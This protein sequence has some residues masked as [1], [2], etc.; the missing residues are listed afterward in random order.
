MGTS[1]CAAAAFLDFSKAFDAVHHCL[2]LNKLEKYGARGIAHRLMASYLG[3]IKHYCCFDDHCSE[4]LS[5]TICVPQG[6]GGSL[7]SLLYILYTNDINYLM[8]DFNPILFADDTTL[9][10]VVENPTVLSLELNLHLYKISDW[11]N[12][13]R[14]ALNSQKSI[15]VYFQIVM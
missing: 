11:C 10:L 15:W 4:T 13:N 7:G 14:L 6:S 3:N 8:K 9:V 12:F 5:C 2:M 1:K